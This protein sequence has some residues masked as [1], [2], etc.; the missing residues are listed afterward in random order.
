MLGSAV[1]LNALNTRRTQVSVS[2]DHVR[3]ASRS[4][5]KI[6]PT[7]TDISDCPVRA[8]ISMTSHLRRRACSTNSWSRTVLPTPQSVE[9]LAPG[10]Q[11][12]PRSLERRR[13]RQ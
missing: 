10:S 4:S 5:W 3:P 7:S 1:R 9:N 13:I 2:P 11:T 12:Q 6:W 8:S